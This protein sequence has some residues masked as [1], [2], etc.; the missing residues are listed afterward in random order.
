M[1]SLIAIT[2]GLA[3]AGAALWSASWVGGRN[4]ILRRIDIEVSNLQARGL[5]MTWQA[6][7]VTG[8][9]LGYDIRLDDVTITGPLGQR[10]VRAGAID[11]SVDVDEGMVTALL[12][13]GMVGVMLVPR[14][15]GSVVEVP[16]TIESTGMAATMQTTPRGT[17][18]LAVVADRLA[19][20]TGA[21]A[22]A[23]VMPVS[24]IAD[25]IETRL[26]RGP[27]GLNA[28]FIAEQIATG[29]QTET[30]IE[31]ATVTR[32]TLTAELGDIVLGSVVRVVPESVARIAIGTGTILT[33]AQ[34]APGGPLVE[35]NR[36]GG[37]TGRLVVENGLLEVSTEAR[38]IAITQP[39]AS[40]G[41]GQIT[42]L[43]AL[44][45]LNLPMVDGLGY[46]DGAVN[47][48][49]TEIEADAAAWQALDPSGG[50]E[51]NTGSVDISM[52]ASVKVAAEGDLVPVGGLPWSFSNVSVAPSRIALFGAVA[53]AEGDVEVLQPMNIPFGEIR[54]GFEAIPDL[55]R[56][57]EGAGLIDDGM[58]AMGDAMLEVYA[59]PGTRP[60]THETT[61]RLQSDGITL[62]GRPLQ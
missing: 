37:A 38:V 45:Q 25:Q 8:F 20:T 3:V 53:T 62:N 27:N 49:V 14:P 4:E 48:S 28:S 35:R 44:A 12:P 9:P 32:P 22:P 21:D 52:D 42:A 50:L 31:T 34:T 55:L 5:S 33:E 47:V 17:Q 40:G 10:A 11:L 29:S 18:V 6:Q 59:S 43:T 19:V 15:D 16:Y 54:L 36:I 60:G 57:L 41:T 24:F 46:T 56:A 58:K 61:I 30:G 13:P 39:M 7:T 51:R 26:E 23:D 1:K 2:T